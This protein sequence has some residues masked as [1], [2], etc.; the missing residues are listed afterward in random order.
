MKLSQF[1]I[2]I[3][4]TVAVAQRA[5]QAKAL[6]IQ[7]VADSHA[8]QLSAMP[9]NTIQNEAPHITSICPRQLAQAP[10]K[11]ITS[12]ETIVK[13]VTNIVETTLITYITITVT[14]EVITITTLRLTET[15][16]PSPTTLNFT[17][18]R[19][20]T[21][22]LPPSTTTLPA[23]TITTSPE[24][25][26]YYS[27]GW[28][29]STIVLACLLL[30][31]I[32][33]SAIG[34][35]WWERH[36]QAEQRWGRRNFGGGE[37]IPEHTQKE[38]EFQVMST[39]SASANS[40]KTGASLHNEVRMTPQNTRQHPWDTLTP[41]KSGAST[42]TGAGRMNPQGMG[43]NPWTGPCEY[44][45]PPPLSL[46]NPKLEDISHE[47]NDDGFAVEPRKEEKTLWG[48]GSD[49]W[50]DQN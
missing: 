27:M 23:I 17:S 50:K 18:T 46:R 47:L 1:S 7:T 44:D 40:Q 2:L 28:R 14:K 3:L 30:P 35:I 38:I 43:S 34:A 12:H 32:A 13:T 20:L 8:T 45:Y 26:R 22:T 15:L 48:I 42:Q 5:H 9:R 21:S 6:T 41:Q 10:P 16:T 36:Q 4:A 39:A 33:G 11:T 29:N 49:R 24:S 31:I 37:M 25:S 19:L